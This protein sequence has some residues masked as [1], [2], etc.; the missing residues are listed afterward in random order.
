MK[1]FDEA[2][3]FWQAAINREENI[4]VLNKEN[5]GKIIK[6]RIKREKKIVAEYFWASLVY[7]IFVYSFLFHFIIKFW[8]DMYLLLLSAA[9]IIL[10]IPFTFV[11][12]RK[13]KAMYNPPVNLTEDILANVSNQ[14]SLLS[15]FF[16]FK[17]RF[18]RIAIPV[19]CF[20]ITAILINLYTIGGIKEHVTGSIVL[21]LIWLTL[22]AT[23]TWFENKKRFRLPLNQLETILKD[24]GNN[25]KA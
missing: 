14:Y 25:Q 13:F 6:S 15:Q 24:I 11:L 7:Q 20:I 10:Y 18:D 22:F 17:K 5:F 23:A 16:R 1:S 4:S 9:G 8:G 3:S 12:M 19:S 2:K 21:F